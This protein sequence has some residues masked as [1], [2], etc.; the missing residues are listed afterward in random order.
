M[1]PTQ[2]IHGNVYITKYALTKGIITVID[3]ELCHDHA[4]IFTNIGSTIPGSFPN[5][6]TYFHKGEWFISWDEAVANANL[7]RD[8]KIKNLKKQ[9]SILE[10]TWFSIPEFSVYFLY[11]R[12]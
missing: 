3:P 10:N 5:Y 4:N 7:R 8:R 6:Y 12:S 11:R 2:T 9:I 1:Q